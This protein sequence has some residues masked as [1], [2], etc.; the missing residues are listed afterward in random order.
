MGYIGRNAAQAYIDDSRHQA[1]TRPRDIMD[2]HFQR[3]HDNAVAL[4]RDCLLNLI[5]DA[6]RFDEDVD[7]DEVNGSTVVYVSYH[8]TTDESQLRELT[9]ALGIRIQWGE[10]VGEAL[11]RT[12]EEDVQAQSEQ[13]A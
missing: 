12:L 13:S 6:K 11:H 4:A 8:I 9:E 1:S 7:G 2:E 5:A 3:V 10:S